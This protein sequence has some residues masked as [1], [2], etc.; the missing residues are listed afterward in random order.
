M[1]IWKIE[2]E[3]C[4]T[5]HI[6]S[7]VSFRFHSHLLW[8]SVDLISESNKKMRK[9]KFRKS[10]K[11]RDHTTCDLQINRNM[12]P[13]WINWNSISTLKTVKFDSSTKKTSTVKHFKNP[14]LFSFE[15]KS[16]KKIIDQTR[17]GKF[18]FYHL[19]IFSIQGRLLKI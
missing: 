18:S 10:H 6:L 14:F 1:F 12:L 7:F 3:R 4:W 2:S 8:I 19:I 11:Y 13:N 15:P 9:R 16:I 5:K 17:G